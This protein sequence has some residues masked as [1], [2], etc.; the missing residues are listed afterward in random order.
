LPTPLRLTPSI[1]QG[2]RQGP[3]RLRIAAPPTQTSPADDDEIEGID[4][5]LAPA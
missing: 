4:R 5:A 2:C 3:W 1:Q